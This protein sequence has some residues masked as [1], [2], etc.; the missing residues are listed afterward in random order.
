MSL[1]WRK[2]L[3][4]GNDAI[5]ADHKHLLEIINQIRHCLKVN[6]RS[7]LMPSIESLYTFLIVHFSREEKIAQAVRHERV[8]QLGES[9]A[10]LLIKLN[11]LKQES[12][13]EW[14]D[15]QAEQLNKFMT[16]MLK[17]IV[18]EDLLMNAAL[19]KYSPSFVPN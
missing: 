16:D 12:S 3:S 9:H 13:V 7:K 15:S 6:D 17:H 14:A 2:Q 18:K 10:E 8:S 5:D 19:R 11:Q 4:V 1:E